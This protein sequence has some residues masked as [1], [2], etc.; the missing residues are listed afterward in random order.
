MLPFTHFSTIPSIMTESTPSRLSIHSPDP[1]KSAHFFAPPGTSSSTDITQTTAKSTTKKIQMSTIRVQD[2]EFIPSLTS[3]KV[4]TMRIIKAKPPSPGEN[5]FRLIDASSQPSFQREDALA[6]SNCLNHSNLLQESEE[7]KNVRT[8]EADKVKLSADETFRELSNTS[9]T[10]NSYIMTPVTRSMS[11]GTSL[12]SSSPKNQFSL[13]SDCTITNRS[14]SSL[15]LNLKHASTSYKIKDILDYDDNVSTRSSNIDDDYRTARDHSSG[16][17]SNKNYGNTSLS[18]DVREDEED[19]T[20]LICKAPCIPTSLIPEEECHQ[21]NLISLADHRHNRPEARSEPSPVNASNDYSTDASSLSLLYGRG[22]SEMKSSKRWKRKEELGFWHP[23][24]TETCLEGSELGT[25]NVEASC[26]MDE[27]VG[28]M[29]DM[30]LPDL[31]PHPPNAP[32][33]KCH[34]S[35]HSASPPLLTSSSSSASLSSSL[36]SSP[37][38][39]PLVSSGYPLPLQLTQESMLLEEG[40][41]DTLHPQLEEER[42]DEV[43]SRLCRHIRRED[44]HEM[45]EVDQMGEDRETE[46]ST[47]EVV[48]SQQPHCCPHNFH[49]SAFSPQLCT[50]LSPI[51]QSPAPTSTNRLDLVHHRCPSQHISAGSISSPVH[52]DRASLVSEREMEQLTDLNSAIPWRESTRERGANGVGINSNAARSRC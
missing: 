40:Q 34:S 50:T 25:S 2:L 48:E 51:P 47:S 31:T 43:E 8:N 7:G 9:E 27:S 39:L 49:A 14:D 12:I 4:E 24:P 26:R 37:T 42:L 36:S 41:L 18:F 10:M 15:D 23:T 32:G 28:Q 1:S 20:T 30:I 6:E 13:I 45:E 11:I 38:S 29:G 52:T 35:F 33:V 44:E 22:N 16:I 19:T 3:S 5:K 21:C 17:N 46:D